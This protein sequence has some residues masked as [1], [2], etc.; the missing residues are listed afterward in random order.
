MSSEAKPTTTTIFDLPPVLDT[1][2][3]LR[4]ADQQPRTQSRIHAKKVLLSLKPQHRVEPTLKPS[5]TVRLSTIV[6][7][8]LRNLCQRGGDFHDDP[9]AVNRVFKFVAMSLHLQHLMMVRIIADSQS[10]D[11]SLL[12]TFTTLPV[13]T[14][15]VLGDKLSS[16]DPGLTLAILKNCPPS[17]QRLD[18]CCLCQGDERDERFQRAESAVAESEKSYQWKRFESL[19]SLS[20]SCDYGGC[21]SWAHILLLKNS[22]HL[23]LLSLMSYDPRG[24]PELEAFQQVLDTAIA[25]C[26]DIDRLRVDPGD[27]PLT[28]AG[29]VRLIQ[30]YPKGLESLIVSM[31]KT[32]QE[33]VISAIFQ[34][35]AATLKSLYFDYGSFTPITLNNDSIT[36]PI[37]EFP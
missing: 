37:Q 6:L 17:L 15:L 23:R 25:C 24:E 35:S 4:Q 18:L 2:H 8:N 1:T 16:S 14:R 12:S 3:L 7:S 32:G 27:I 26:P 36:R 31:P 13:L 20:I 10:F 11:N 33:L 22:P 5:G 34:T 21:E 19:K 9:V 29:L 28:A 30:A